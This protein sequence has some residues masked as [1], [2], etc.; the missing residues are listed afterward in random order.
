MDKESVQLN[1]LKKR[2][3]EG[4]L[5][6]KT[7]IPRSPNIV[8]EHL[9]AQIEQ[10]LKNDQYNF[11]I[12]NIEPIKSLGELFRKILEQDPIFGEHLWQ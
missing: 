8:P 11:C 2:F 3:C 1:E 9:R 12:R 5:A 7:A 6:L 10:Q 4:Y